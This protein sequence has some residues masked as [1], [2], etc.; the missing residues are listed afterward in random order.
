MSGFAGRDPREGRSGE[1]GDPRRGMTIEPGA[2]ADRS[3]S[4]PTISGVMP[5]L[6]PGARMNPL[7]GPSRPSCSMAISADSRISA[8][9]CAGVIT[10]APACL[11]ASA[12][13]GPSAAWAGGVTT[14]TGLAPPR[15]SA[16]T[17][18]PIKGWPSNGSS[19]LG[20]PIRRLLP[21]AGTMAGMVMELMTC[22]RHLAGA[23]G[24]WCPG[25]AGRSIRPRC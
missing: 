19:G 15:R 13:G 21:A 3:R 17:T 14:R 24:P 20:R 23:P 5:G 25:C 6:S 9:Q 18:R 22:S 4:R 12:M 11:A 7:G 8:G 16:E 2:F 1:C 10:A